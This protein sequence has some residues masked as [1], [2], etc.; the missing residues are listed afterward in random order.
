METIDSITKSDNRVSKLLDTWRHI[1]EEINYF[2]IFNHAEEL[3]SRLGYKNGHQIVHVLRAG[4]ENLQKVGITTLYDLSGRMFQRLIADRKFLATFYTLP[5]SANLLA[6]IAIGQLEKDWSNGD[7]YQNL[8]IADLAC[9]TGTLLAAAYRKILQNYQFTGKDS[10]DIHPVM[11]E[12]CVFAA[13][14]MPAASHLA[15]SQLVGFH[16]SVKVHRAQVHTMPYGAQPEESGSDI[17]IGSLDL[18]DRDRVKS[19]FPTGSEE[20]MANVRD[21]LRDELVIPDNYLDLIIMNPPF[22]S[23]TNHKVA[24]VPV[25]S[26]AGFSTSEEEQSLMSLKL[27]RITR[28]FERRVGDGNAGLASNFCDLVH[29]K[30]KPGGTFALV[31]PIAA[32]SGK[33]W[34]K[35]RDL[36]S[37]SYTNIKIL[38]I[39]NGKSRERAFSADTNMAECLLIANKCGQD[40]NSTKVPW[41]LVNLTS[42]PR[43]LFESSEFANQIREAPI[44]PRGT[45]RLGNDEIGIY[46]CCQPGQTFTSAIRSPE[47][48]TFLSHF[49]EDKHVRIR[50]S[51]KVQFSLTEIEKIG[52]RG[53]VDRDVGVVNLDAKGHRGAFAISR[54]SEPSSL[55]PVLWWHDT[56]RERNF[57]ILPDSRGD[58]IHG[59]EKAAIEVW[60]TAS[61]IHISRDFSTT[62]QSIVLC[63]TPTPSLGGRAWPTIKLFN[64]KWETLLI[65]WFNSTLGMMSLWASGSKQHS[66]RS[67]LTITKIP[68]LAVLDPSS[69]AE[70]DIESANAFYDS[71]CDK[72]FLPACDAFKDPNRIELDN[73]VLSTL[74]KVPEDWHEDFGVIR[75]LWCK[76]PIVTGRSN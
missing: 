54:T 23:P 39:V 32:L 13:D 69:I 6:E 73:F 40:M 52:L 19:L 56:K 9:G 36:L 47:L 3:L 41:M 45:L 46:T 64:E 31:L 50:S 11:L 59:R 37:T 72:D 42:R 29:Q 71:I 10:A 17:S 76:E 66:G 28:R 49:L 55:Y 20:V 65:L 60:D 24:T 57:E 25:P 8:H 4:V 15:A 53:K 33:S 7:T 70:E 68:E 2:P 18:L 74:C 63:R 14:I 12:K 48:I 21:S 5:T 43:S 35:F 61:R 1:K 16:P 44:Q 51:D 34:E 38:T 26:F 30:L 22:T 75:E 27:T 67:I 62:S 58:V